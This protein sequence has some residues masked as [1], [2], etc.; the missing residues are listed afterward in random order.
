MRNTAAYPITREEIRDALNWAVK[1]AAAEGLVGSMRPAA[2]H[3]AG[4]HLDR[5]TD[6]LR[7]IA[8]MHLAGLC[9]LRMQRIAQSALRDIPPG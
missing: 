4:V 9:G 3:E 6:A 1:E 7:E 8:E 5:L 2:L